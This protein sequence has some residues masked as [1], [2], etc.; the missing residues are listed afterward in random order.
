MTR[1]IASCGRASVE[2]AGTILHSRPVVCPMLEEMEGACPVYA[3]RPVACRTY[4]SYVQRELG[5]CRGDI[6]SRVAGG[7]WGDVVWGNHNAVDQA[8]GALGEVRALTE[9]VGSAFLA[10]ASSEERQARWRWTGS[11]STGFWRE[12]H[13]GHQSRHAVIRAG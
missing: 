12:G 3:Q 8:L 13:C 5:L 7:E 2:H 9:A 6:E 1:S 10:P 11:A 4:G